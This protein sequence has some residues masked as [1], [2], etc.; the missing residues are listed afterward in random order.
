MPRVGISDRTG[1]MRSV[2]W[3]AE[4]LAVEWGTG[5]TWRPN[6]NPHPHE[7]H[8]LRLDCAKAHER[9]GWRPRCGWGQRWL[10]P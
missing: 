7:A 5:A 3:L 8:Y 6:D 2:R 9:L 10:K 4:H 1:P